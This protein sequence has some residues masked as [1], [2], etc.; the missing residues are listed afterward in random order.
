[1]SLF[2]SHL[3]HTRLTIT[4]VV[5]LAISLATVGAVSATHGPA[6]PP[7]DVVFLVDELLSMGQLS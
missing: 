7:V 3:S 5:L 6:H 2:F 1:M 4:M